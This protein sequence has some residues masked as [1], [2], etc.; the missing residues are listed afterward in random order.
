MKIW[1][2]SRNMSE[3]PLEM[4]LGMGNTSEKIWTNMRI[5]DPSNCGALNRIILRKTW[6]NTGTNQSQWRFIAGKTIYTTYIN[7]TEL[8]DGF[9]IAMLD[10]GRVNDVY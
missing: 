1:E 9:S 5:G 3:N 2:T 4:G 10:Y 8:N 7:G 6:E